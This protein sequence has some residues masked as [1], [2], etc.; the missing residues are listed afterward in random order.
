MDQAAALLIRSAA[1]AKT[2]G[3]P[4]GRWVFPLA[5]AEANAMVPV[6]ARVDLHDCPGAGIAGRAALAAA[7]LDVAGL[8]VAEL[9]LM[10]L[11]SCFPAAV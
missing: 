10:E 7:G 9:D 5:H 6:S 2:A 1:A 3:M 11:Y 4:R 8:D